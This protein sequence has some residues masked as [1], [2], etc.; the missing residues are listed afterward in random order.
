MYG[1]HY[2]QAQ[3]GMM[4]E[5]ANRLR[6]RAATARE[7]DRNREF[8]ALASYCEEAAASMEDFTPSGLSGEPA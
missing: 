8:L 1:V 2:L 7:S 6:E 3:A 4:R 5:Q